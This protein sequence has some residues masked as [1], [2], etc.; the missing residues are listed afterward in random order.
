[1][2]SKSGCCLHHHD[3]G[4]LLYWGNKVGRW[5]CFDVWL[6]VRVR[7]RVCAWVHSDFEWLSDHVMLGWLNAFNDTFHIVTSLITWLTCL[8]RGKKVGKGACVYVCDYVDGLVYIGICLVLLQIDFKQKERCRGIMEVLNSWFLSIN[9][10]LHRAM[11]NML[12]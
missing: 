1:M 7:A 11:E 10:Q 6:C 4:C 3:C 5:V 2:C 9:S 12:F 8:C